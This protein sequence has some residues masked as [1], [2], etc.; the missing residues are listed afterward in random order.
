MLCSVP[1]GM[2]C[3]GWGLLWVGG[4]EMGLEK[5][6]QMSVSGPWRVAAQAAV[7]DQHYDRQGSTTSG[8]A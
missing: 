5:D 6:M 2:F 1:F 8:Q 3:S 4:A 7:T